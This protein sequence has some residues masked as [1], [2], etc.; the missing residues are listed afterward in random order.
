MSAP[1]PILARGVEALM[2]AYKNETCLGIIGV[3]IYREANGSIVCR[4]VIACAG[5]DPMSI[6][7]GIVELNAEVSKM[8]E[9]AAADERSEDAIDVPGFGRGVYVEKPGRGNA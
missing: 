6:V 4:Q 1:D 7:A 3:S 2:D 9:R 5:A 8:L